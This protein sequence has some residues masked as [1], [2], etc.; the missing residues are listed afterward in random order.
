MRWQQLK[1]MNVVLSQPQFPGFMT[2]E[3]PD[4]TSSDTSDASPQEITGN[5][6]NARDTFPTAVR[7]P[8]TR[9]SVGDRE[10]SM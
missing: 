8:C 6:P 3:S 10:F 1:G 5:V 9:E 2:H 4:A 7:C